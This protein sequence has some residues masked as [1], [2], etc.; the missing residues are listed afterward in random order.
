MCDSYDC[1]LANQASVFLVSICMYVMII[2]ESRQ[3][4]LL[5]VWWMKGSNGKWC[6]DDDKDEQIKRWYRKK[7][8]NRLNDDKILIHV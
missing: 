5:F 6:D 2:C 1:T 7:A 4:F 3:R 8:F